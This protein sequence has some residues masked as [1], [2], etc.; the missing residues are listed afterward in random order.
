M[1]N[2]V[3]ALSLPEQ[4]R[5]LSLTAIDAVT[6]SRLWRVRSVVLSSPL[7]I[8]YGTGPCAFTA[9]NLRSE[10]TFAGM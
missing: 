2:V 1:R 4:K 9:E 10:L 3:E 5:H 6:V 8:R 7:P